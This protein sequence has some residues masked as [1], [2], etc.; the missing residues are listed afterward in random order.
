M[1]YT[2][3]GDEPIARADGAGVPGASAASGE[4][5]RPRRRGRRAGAPEPDSYAQQWQAEHDTPERAAAATADDP[6]AGVDETAGTAQFVGIDVSF[7]DTDVT[8]VRSQ[9][10]APGAAA[11]RSAPQHA[12]RLSAASG[13]ASVPSAELP[14][15][16][17]PVSE[18][19]VSELPAPELIAAT[20]VRLGVGHVFGVVGSGNFELVGALRARDVPF[21][22]ARHEGGAATMADA[23]SRVSRTLAVVTTHQGCGYTN[24]LTG[25]AEAAKSRTPLLVV[26]AAAPVAH[27]HNNFQMDQDATAKSVGAVALRVHS[28]ATAVDDVELAWRTAV[29]D[30]RTVVLS[31]PID[32]LPDLAPDTTGRLRVP[33]DGPASA[34]RTGAEAGA[35][36]PEPGTDR[37]GD[38]LHRV[39]R[40]GG[41]APAFEIQQLV[42]LLEASERP[43]FIAGRGAR[44]AGP[45]IAAVAEHWGAL[46]A[47]SAVAKGLFRAGVDGRALDSG[48]ADLGISGGFSTP[49]AAELIAGADLVVAWGCALND[50]TTRRG[51]LVESVTIAQVDIDAMALGAHRPI[52]LG[53]VGDSASVASDVLASA[54]AGAGEGPA[55]E[56]YRTPDV[57]A[58]IRDEG[59]WQAMPYDDLGSSTTI[60]PRAVTIALDEALPAERIVA[61]DSGNFMGY[62]SQFLDVPDLAGFCFT[63]AFQAVGLGLATII[64]AAAARPDRLPVLGIGDGGFH[65]AVAE[66][67]TAVRLGI[68]LVVLVYNDASYAAEVHHFSAAP[69]PGGAA[70]FESVVFP[71]T[72]IAAIARGFGAQ[73]ITVRSNDDLAAMA[74]AVRETAQHGAG[75]GTP[76]VIDAKIASD[77]GS[78]WLAE[79]FLAH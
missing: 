51:R 37:R 74:V 60:D 21:T 77:G 53:V 42:Q 29:V 3:D 45:E 16:E 69:T 12:E 19:P 44:E 36:A 61:V 55:R 56:G 30:R 13:H 65:M 35:G 41:R 7:T 27:P 57:L 58:R 62:P 14:V 71:D 34:R 70:D 54:T 63:Q 18:L 39:E 40:R 20:L 78:W 49:V 1:R 15:S 24:A 38:G 75:Q 50:W 67:E 79:A 32:L 72:D 59:R 73:G 23:F 22:A 47:T 66:L 68:P 48:G 2:A 4:P 8:P 26:T 10:G 9:A 64:G 46:L 76:L 33:G 25:I 43:V 17:L 11:A 52:D 28:A 6:F 31:V 5:E